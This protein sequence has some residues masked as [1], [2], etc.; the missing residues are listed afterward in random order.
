M[1]LSGPIEMIKSSYSLNDR[2]VT[3]IK[4]FKTNISKS[5]GNLLRNYE[6]WEFDSRSILLGLH[7]YQDGTTIK[8][9]GFITL[10]TEQECPVY[11]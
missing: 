8:G 9:L 2:A 6:E 3:A 4:Y 5:Y 11:E 10:E 1:N 7:G